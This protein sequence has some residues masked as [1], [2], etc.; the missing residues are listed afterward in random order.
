MAINMC[1]ELLLKDGF[2]LPVGFTFDPT[3]RE[4]V[5]YYLTRKVY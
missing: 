1:G 4:L 2:N 3:D 5:G